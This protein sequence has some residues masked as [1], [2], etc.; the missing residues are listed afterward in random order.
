MKVKLVHWAKWWN[1]RCVE[2]ARQPLHRAHKFKIKFITV[3][4][5]KNHA[6]LD[7]PSSCLVPEKLARWRR[8]EV[9]ML[10]SPLAGKQRIFKKTVLPTL[11]ISIEKDGYSLQKSKLALKNDFKVTYNFYFKIFLTILLSSRD[12]CLEHLKQ[13]ILHINYNIQNLHIA[14]K[15]KSKLLQLFYDEHR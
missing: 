12:I 10:Q 1:I 11:R 5:C 15:E 2:F 3:W 9:N 4:T 7:F 8:N 6:T 14:I 13:N